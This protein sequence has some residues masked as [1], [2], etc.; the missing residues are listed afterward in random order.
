MSDATTREW[1]FY[2]E[3]MIGFVEKINTNKAFDSSASQ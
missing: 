1:H 3:D 2:V